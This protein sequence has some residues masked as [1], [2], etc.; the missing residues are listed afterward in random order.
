MEGG[1][2]K[3]DHEKWKVDHEKCDVKKMEHRNCLKLPEEKSEMVTT[4]KIKHQ[5]GKTS[6]TQKDQVKNHH[7]S[8]YDP[9]QHAPVNLVW[10]HDKGAHL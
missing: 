9:T 2:W 1:R 6:L 7:N 8:N 4:G 5:S 10:K 3:V